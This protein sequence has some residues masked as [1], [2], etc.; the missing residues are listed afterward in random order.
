M[1]G[2]IN[3]VS[4]GYSLTHSLTHPPT[5]SLTHSLTHPPTH[6]LTNSLTHWSNLFKQIVDFS[7]VCTFSEVHPGDPQENTSNFK[8]YILRHFRTQDP[9][10]NLVTV[11]PKEDPITKDPK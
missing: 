11:E 2:R 7:K 1:Q 8:K 10:K 9:R 5:H 3:I 4:H 6:S